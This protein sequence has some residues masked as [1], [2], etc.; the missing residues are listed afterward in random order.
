MTAKNRNEA[1]AGLL[2]GLEP[3][4]GGFE[5]RPYK[6]NLATRAQVAA[7][8]VRGTEQSEEHRQQCV[9]SR[10]ILYAYTGRSVHGDGPLYELIQKC[11]GRPDNTV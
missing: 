11:K 4:Q 10:D 1:G 6:K 3:E 2:D 8:A 5:T 7:E 9:R